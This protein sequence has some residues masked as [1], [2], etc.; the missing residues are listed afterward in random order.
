M[1]FFGN[2]I[3]PFHGATE[4]FKRR[5]SLMQ[6]DTRFV[7]DAEFDATDRTHSKAD[8]RFKS[9][10]FLKT[11][12]PELVHWVRRLL[13]TLYTKRSK[14]YTR[15]Q[16]MPRSISELN[17]DRLNLGGALMAAETF[18]QVVSEFLGLCTELYVKPGR[19][20]ASDGFV[21]P[22]AEI[23]CETFGH[24]YGNDKKKTAFEDAMA[25]KYTK[26]AHGKIWC[27]KTPDLKKILVL[28]PERPTKRASLQERASADPASSSAPLV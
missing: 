21:P 27:Y 17:E 13:P 18:S 25:K 6:I 20:K 8:S 26:G 15:L 3:P 14:S 5:P 23:V 24:W 1:I 7:S 10:E 19:G 2:T 4:A 9:P 11:M 28:K 16:P 12:A 22:K